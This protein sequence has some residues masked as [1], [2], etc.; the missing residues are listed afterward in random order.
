MA[1]GIRKVSDV[2]H[3]Y[4]DNGR[5]LYVSYFSEQKVDF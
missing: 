4:M 1:T 2:R 3:L 5:S